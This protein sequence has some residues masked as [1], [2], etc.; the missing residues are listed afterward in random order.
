[1]SGDPYNLDLTV[2]QV[3]EVIK[4]TGMHRLNKEEW[5]GK[6]EEV[7]VLTCM[8]A[9]GYIGHMGECRGTAKLS[10]IKKAYKE[11]ILDKDGPTQFGGEGI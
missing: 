2:D 3:E 8:S 7:P 10:L 1:M 4:L 9:L 5:D 6:S 11:W